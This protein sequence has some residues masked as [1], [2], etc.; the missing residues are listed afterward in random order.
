VLPFVLRDL[1]PER[2]GRPLDLLRGDAEPRQGAEEFAAF[3]KADQRRRPHHARH[4]RGE[5][6]AV[7]PQCPVPRA[8]ALV[9]GGAVIV[10]PRQGE[11]PQ[12]RGE[13]LRV[14]PGVA[15][16]AAAAATRPPGAGVIR[17]VG[18][19]VLREEARREL[20]GLPPEGN[21]QRL[22]V[23]RGGYAGSEERRDLAARLRLEGRAEPPFSA[24]SCAA[25]AGASS[26][27]SAQRSH[28]SQ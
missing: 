12:G 21:L 22:E 11:R 25:A 9:A 6:R 18:V 8:E 14:A 23:K 16:G 5:R 10:G 2:L 27:A 20:Q 24:A 26:S 7:Y 13:C 19:E 3:G 4:G 17:G 1:A 15:G 28:A